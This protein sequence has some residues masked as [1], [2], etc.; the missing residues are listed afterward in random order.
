[1]KTDIR[2]T[3][4][5]PRVTGHRPRA[6]VTLVEI[7]IVLAIITL[8]ASM[9]IGMATHID[10]Q[11]RSRSLENTFA[12]L[13]SALQEYREYRGRFPYAADPDPN[14]NSERLYGALNFIPTSRKIVEQISD[15]LI[16]HSVD[17][18]ATPPIP[19]IYDPWSKVLDYRYDVNTDTYPELISAGPDRIFDT[20]DDISSR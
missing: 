2:H 16:R 10:N 20:A 6:A 11:S 18:G 19:E 15:S 7:L 4:Y 13:E 5:E 17:T 8:L 3:I 14:L 1:M 12:L 9:V